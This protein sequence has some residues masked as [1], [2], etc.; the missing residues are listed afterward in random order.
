MFSKS[1]IATLLV[2]LGSYMGF[3][4]LQK[5]K[6]VSRKF[7]PYVRVGVAAAIILQ[8][9]TLNRYRVQTNIWSFASRVLNCS[10]ERLMK[11]E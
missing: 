3:F 6:P 7:E 2:L 5:F 10:N 8:E 4:V 9:I 1:H 11:F